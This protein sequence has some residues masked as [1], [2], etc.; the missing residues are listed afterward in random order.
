MKK[1][2]AFLEHASAKETV[3]RKKIRKLPSIFK[4]F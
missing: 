1:Y 2:S 3:Q 4:D